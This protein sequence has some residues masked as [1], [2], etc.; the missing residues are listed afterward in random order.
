MNRYKIG[1]GR[2]YGGT[3]IGSRMF[4]LR[5]LPFPMPVIVYI[6]YMFTRLVSQWKINVIHRKAPFLLS[7]VHHE[8]Y[9][10]WLKALRTQQTVGGPRAAA[11]VCPRPSPPPWAPK[12]LPPL[13]RR[14]RSSSFPRP[15]RSRAHHCSRLTRQYGGEQRGL[16]NLTFDLLT[17]KVMSESRVTWATSVSIWYYRY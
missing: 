8:G 6:F 4:S 7:L 16:V 15:T 9:F 1:E 14:Q 2:S 3:L 11:T 10:S 17:L 12:R 5:F 13:S